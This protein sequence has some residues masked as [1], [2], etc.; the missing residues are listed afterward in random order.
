MKLFP[1]C[2]AHVTEEKCRNVYEC[3]F[4][5]DEAG[6]RVGGTARASHELT[7][8]LALYSLFAM[9]SRGMHT[10]IL[11]REDAFEPVI[12]ARW[13]DLLG[14]MGVVYEIHFRIDRDEGVPCRNAW[15]SGVLCKALV[16]LLMSRAFVEQFEGPTVL[17][18]HAWAWW[19]YGGPSDYSNPDPRQSQAFSSSACAE[20]LSI[21]YNIS[22]E[23]KISA[24]V[25][26]KAS[27]EYGGVSAIA[28]IVINTF[29]SCA[30]SNQAADLKLHCYPASVLYASED[31]D[32][33]G[34]GKKFVEAIHELDGTTKIIK[35]LT[36]LMT[37][38]SGRAALQDSTTA[39]FVMMMAT[40]LLEFVSRSRRH[41]EHAAKNGILELC[42][43]LDPDRGDLPEIITTISKRLLDMLPLYFVYHS[44]IGSY[45]EEMRKLTEGDE[46]KDHRL[47][48]GL[49]AE[50]WRTMKSLLLERYCVK[51]F[52]DFVIAPAPRLKYCNSVWRLHLSTIINLSDT[53]FL[54]SRYVRYASAGN[55]STKFHSL[56]ARSAD[57]CSIARSSARPRIGNKMAIRKIVKKDRVRATSPPLLQHDID[58]LAFLNYRS[59]QHRRPLS[60][61]LIKHIRQRSVLLIDGGVQKDG[62]GH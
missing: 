56:R 31:T 1:V 49:F 28:D 13:E 4:K 62:A 8:H 25:A 9:G 38:S 19:L 3:F 35:G 44:V 54:L 2:C 17:Y 46:P 40:I 18:E 37:S 32:E 11:H 7:F 50:S 6:A 21:L 12:L 23:M 26:L 33:L 27:A 24:S 52:F 47:T 39:A 57:E 41:V 45:A 14:A 22:K 53:S 43:A 51:R 15:I 16:V 30:T 48:E 20:C 61:F 42:I 29:Y 59:I 55:R 60:V 5:T 34:K 36:H 58:V 10:A